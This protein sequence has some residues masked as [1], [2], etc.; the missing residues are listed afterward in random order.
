MIMLSKCKC[1][2]ATLLEMA[3]GGK[4]RFIG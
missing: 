2:Q 1:P 4:K 3:N